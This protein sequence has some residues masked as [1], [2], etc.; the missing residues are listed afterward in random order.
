MLYFAGY[1]GMS[2]MHEYT[3]AIIRRV[4]PG[5]AL[6][7]YDPSTKNVDYFGIPV[8]YGATV[9]LYYDEKRNILNGITPDRAKFWEG[10][11]ST[12]ELNRYES[13]ARMSRLEDRVREMI[14]IGKAFLL[15]CQRLWAD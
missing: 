9:A 1:M 2:Y 7:R 4:M 12:M 3:R 13:L 15:F 6:I 8:P 5:G 11:L 14:M 10:N